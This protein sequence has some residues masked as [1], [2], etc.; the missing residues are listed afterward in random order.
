M[1]DIYDERLNTYNVYLL[2]GNMIF[3]LS[4]FSFYQNIFKIFEKSN[5]NKE[6][7]LDNN[8]FYFK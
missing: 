1:Y 3:N 5:L 8:D 7:H 4:L 2:F 6:H